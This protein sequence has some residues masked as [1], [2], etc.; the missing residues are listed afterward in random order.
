MR[1]TLIEAVLK[2]VQDGDFAIEDAID[3]IEA[4]YAADSTTQI[5]DP[6]GEP[7]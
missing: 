3:R 2:Q 4:I 6:Y 5:S 7:E 1:R